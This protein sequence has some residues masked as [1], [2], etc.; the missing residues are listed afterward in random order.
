MRRKIQG[1]YGKPVLSHPRKNC[2]VWLEARVAESRNLSF[3]AS[4]ALEGKA[5]KQNHRVTRQ[6]NPR[7]RRLEKFQVQEDDGGMDRQWDLATAESS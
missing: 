2:P 6:P 1:K 4:R 3:C 5:E 7:K